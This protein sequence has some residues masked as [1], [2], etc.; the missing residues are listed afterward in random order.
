[1]PAI[2]TVLLFRNTSE[3]E[4]LPGH[5]PAL[6]IMGMG[7]RRYIAC[8]TLCQSIVSTTDQSWVPAFAI[9][10]SDDIEI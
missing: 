10:D 1:M 6:V 9:I 8:A 5:V 7:E 3:R 4:H 2:M